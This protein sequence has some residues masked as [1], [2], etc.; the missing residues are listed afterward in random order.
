[1]TSTVPATDLRARLRSVR[2]PVPV[3]SRERE[4]ALTARQREVLDQLARLFD[5]GFAHLTMADIARRLSCSL[6]TLYGL[7]PSRDELVLIAIDRRLWRI[8]RAAAAAID[9]TDAPLDA[10]RAYLRAANVAVADTTPAFA[11]DVE[12]LAATRALNDS[13]SD[14]IVAVA[15]CL[16]DIAQERSDIS[17][18]DTAAV[19]RVVAGVGRDFSKPEVLASLGSNPRAA[20]D[21]IVDIVVRGLRPA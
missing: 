20:A 4:E 3:L 17:S 19:A 12:A 6:R 14:Y 15:R 9:A 21:E 11:R 5:E 10:L 16:L 18:V 1:M 2:R 7:A 13:H 8:G